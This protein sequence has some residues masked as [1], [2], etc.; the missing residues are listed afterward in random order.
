[1]SESDKSSEILI[2]LIAFLCFVLF[3][4]DQSE[5]AVKR[6]WDAKRGEESGEEEEEEEKVLE[7][8]VIAMSER[9]PL[10]PRAQRAQPF[11]LVLIEYM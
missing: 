3:V 8:A 2:L 1:M 9:N 4:L 11:E 5:W 10:K 6:N 7:E